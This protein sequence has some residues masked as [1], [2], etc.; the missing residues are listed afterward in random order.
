MRSIV[1]NEGISVLDILSVL[2][3]GLAKRVLVGKMARPL[4]MKLFTKEKGGI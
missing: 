1:V 3:D 4:Y 2:I